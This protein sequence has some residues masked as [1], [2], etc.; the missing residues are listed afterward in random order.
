MI[1]HVIIVAKKLLHIPLMVCIRNFLSIGAVRKVVKGF[2]SVI[3]VIIEIKDIG[4]I[5][6]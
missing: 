5:F 2:M 6:T 1:F 4:V 3:I